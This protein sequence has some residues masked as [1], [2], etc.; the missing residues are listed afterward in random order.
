[1][2]YRAWRPPLNW[3]DHVFPVNESRETQPSW[4][5]SEN[6][7]MSF[8]ALQM[9]AK[10]TVRQSLL[11][12]IDGRP[13]AKAI[14][15]ACALLRKADD[16]TSGAEEA[17]QEL[18]PQ[19]LIAALVARIGGEAVEGD[20]ELFGNEAI[21][22]KILPPREPTDPHKKCADWFRAD[23]EYECSPDCPGRALAAS[24]EE[25]EQEANREAPDPFDIISCLSPEDF[26]L[27]RNVLNYARNAAVGRSD[28]TGLDEGVIVQCDLGLRR[29]MELEP[30]EHDGW[31]LGSVLEALATEK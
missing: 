6:A 10:P 14:G 4:I 15:R 28:R 25:E 20:R 26:K 8:M 29:L 5:S 19:Q 7:V 1:M 11:L 3:L 12:E 17:M 24:T 27:F 31:G 2:K 22:T 13:L 18:S 16:L 30:R 9:G 21:A 23:P